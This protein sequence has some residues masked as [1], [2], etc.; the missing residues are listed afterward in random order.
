MRFVAERFT[1]V[2]LL[3]GTAALTSCMD[4]PLA[5]IELEP[6]SQGEVE[7]PVD[8]NRNLDI[9]FVID[10]SQSM[11]NEQDSLATNF[12]RLIAAIQSIEHGLPD[13]H[14]G[15]VSTDLGIGP[16][17]LPGDGCT[18]TGKMGLLQNS[19]PEGETCPV[20]ADRFI[21]DIE[22]KEGERLRNYEG[23]LAE[24]F[25]CIARL[26][27][28]GCGYEQPLE[29]MRRALGAEHE[30]GGFLRDGARLAVIFVTDEDD[31]STRD[32][33][34]FDRSRADLG[35][36]NGYR[37][38]EYG[39]TCDVSDPR[40][41]GEHASCQPREASPYM[42]DVSEYVSFLRGLKRHPDRDI[43][44]AGIIGESVDPIM[45]DADE[46]GLPLVMQSCFN[47]ELDQDGA[48]PPVRLRAFL[49]EFAFNRQ[50]TICN[51]DLAGALEQIGE[52]IG[53]PPEGACLPGNLADGDPAQEGVQ[54]I[55]SISEVRD[56][57]TDRQTERIIGECERVDDPT[58]SGNLPCYTLAQDPQTCGVGDPG[59]GAPLW[60]KAHYAAGEIVPPTTIIR[61]RC[62][63]N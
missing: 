63:T 1:I 36:D 3:A 34:M 12:D 43:L 26:G 58:V 17:P 28:Q 62:E 37:C 49:Q 23:T 51:A 29:A 56:P 40:A 54:P 35:P 61:A 8:A 24:T 42:Y 57:D 46:R 19:P 25:S 52:F 47:D 5:V 38:F 21:L 60:I 48:F 14:I 22:G 18:E 13:L 45:V 44:V 6:A 41:L 53:P 39:V 15:V 30:S 55:C 10:D 7:F 11:G 59:W 32:Y 4:R 20:P 33:A 27:D 50:A 9:L 16:Y 2:A 31:C